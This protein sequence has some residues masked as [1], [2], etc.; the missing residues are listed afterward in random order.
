MQETTFDYELIISDDCSSDA[1][2]TNCKRNN[3]TYPKGN[4]IKY[5]RHETLECNKWSLF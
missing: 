3:V 5:F 2:R 4:R 1:N